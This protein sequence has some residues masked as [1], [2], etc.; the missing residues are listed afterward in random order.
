MI[1][2]LTTGLSNKASGTRSMIM[3]WYRHI[4]REKV[5]Y[6]F[7]VRPDFD[8]PDLENEILSLGGNIYREQYTHREKPIL[9]KRDLCN[10]F[11]RH[12]EINGVHMNLNHYGYILPLE[13]AEKMNLPIRIAFSHNSGDT[14][15]NEKHFLSTVTNG[16]RKSKLAEMNIKRMTC[17]SAAGKYIFGEEKP[18]EILNNGIMLEKYRFDVE[19]RKRIRQKYE[20]DGGSMLL[21]FV[22]RLQYQKN[23]LFMLQIYKEYKKIYSNS[24][25]LIIGTGE[26]EEECRQYVQEN[27]LTDSVI[28]VGFI[29]DVFAYYSAMDA[30]LLPSRFEGLAVTAVEAQAAGLPIYASDSIAQEHNIV[31]LVHF[32]SINEPAASWANIITAYDGDRLQKNEEMKKAGFDIQDVAQKLETIYTDLYRNNGEK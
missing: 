5:Q 14:R 20:V 19:A 8:Q 17:S 9:F 12:S 30:L 4:N 32:H 28:F 22:G 15:A 18:F 21:G 29:S 23:P 1:R 26:M 10:F 24:K 31:S 16:L 13:I 3:N 2:I 27:K 25:L 7:L 6:D 11:E